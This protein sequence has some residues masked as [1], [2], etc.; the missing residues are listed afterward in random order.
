MTDW[1]Y[2]STKTGG[3]NA[4]TSPANARLSLETQTSVVAGDRVFVAAVHAEVKAGAITITFAG[5]VANPVQV[6]CADLTLET[7]PGPDRWASTGGVTAS[8]NFG[9]TISGSAFIHGLTF[10]A[11][12]GASTAQTLTIGTGTLSWQY[13]DKCTL[14]LGNAVASAAARF[15][16]GVAGSN[17]ANAIIFNEVQMIFGHILHTIFINQGRFEWRNFSVAAFGATV[18]TTLLTGFSQGS[19]T[20]LEGLD[21]IGV[22]SKNIVG[23]TGNNVA[24]IMI[25]GCRF[26]S[27]TIVLSAAIISPSAEV[28]ATNCGPTQADPFASYAAKYVIEGSEVTDMLIARVGGAHDGAYGHSRGYAPL[29]GALAF[30]PY[31]GLPLSKWNDTVGADVTVTVYGFWHQPTGARPTNAQVSMEVQWFGDTAGSKSP[32]ILTGNN[33]PVNAFGELSFASTATTWD[34]DTSDWTGG[35]APDRIAGQLYSVLR[36]PIVVGGKLFLLETAGTSASGGAEAAV[37]ALYAA[38]VDG[39]SVTDG[40]AVFRQPVRFKMTYTMDSATFWE[41]PQIAGPVY[42]I[43]RLS[44]LSGFYVWLDPAIG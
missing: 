5:T 1:Y 43:P 14:R 32:R 29:A 30:K 6:I 11:G 20:L 10:T 35:T 4:G 36:T 17:T 41:Q 39:G 8:G 27:N 24:R 26:A 2:D 19:S 9:I 42:V 22:S 40:T 31:V 13:Y 18:P 44:S 7:P 23:A 15:N 3:T 38:A 25:N 21:F 34:A 33:G 28:I 12:N 16:I 37:L